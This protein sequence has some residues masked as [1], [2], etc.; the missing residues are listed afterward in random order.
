MSEQKYHV[1]AGAA[2]Y[3]CVLG[4]YRGYMTV[5]EIN[6]YLLDPEG[7]DWFEFA[8]VDTDGSLVEDTHMSVKIERTDA[9]FGR[10]YTLI[11]KHIQLNRRT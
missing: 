9:L 1:F 7:A 11:D 10:K 5:E 2:Y 8:Y 3:P 6:A 4:D